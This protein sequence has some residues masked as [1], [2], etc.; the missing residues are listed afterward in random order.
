MKKIFSLAVAVMLSAVSFA[1]TEVGGFFFAPKAGLSVASL[2]NAPD[3]YTNKPGFAVGVEV[4]Y[5][6]TENFAITVDALYSGQGMECEE[7]TYYTDVHT[8][9]ENYENKVSLDYLNIPILANYYIVKGLAVK[10]GIQPCIL[11]SAKSKVK[12]T[13]HDGTEETDIKDNLN[14]IDFSIPVGLSYE[15]NNIILDARYNIGI[16]N[17]NKS[18]KGFNNKDNKNSVFQLTLGY[19]LPF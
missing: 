16:T 4:G 12:G 14:S 11:V 6:M 5:Q 2:T 3:K 1:Q 9:Y 8:T 13:L 17:V 10:A 15:W 19:K 18:G 7:K